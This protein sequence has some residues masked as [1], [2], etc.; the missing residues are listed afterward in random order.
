MKASRTRLYLLSILDKMGRSEVKAAYLHRCINLIHYFTHCRFDSSGPQSN[1][2]GQV[3][4]IAERAIFDFSHGRWCFHTTF[5]RPF[6]WSGNS[7]E[8]L[9]LVLLSNRCILSNMCVCVF[10]RKSAVCKVRERRR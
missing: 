7:R 5:C 4:R 3:L 1:L 10:L 8:L 2:P 6:P 9:S